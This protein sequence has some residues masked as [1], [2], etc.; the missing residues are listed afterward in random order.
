MLQ[1]GGQVGNAGVGGHW[2]SITTRETIVS[3]TL[4]RENG[5]P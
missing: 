2:K 3:S 4:L 1:E 5:H